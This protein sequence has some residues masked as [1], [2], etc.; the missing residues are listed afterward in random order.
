MLGAT[1]EVDHIKDLQ[2]GGTNHVDNLAALCPNCTEIKDI[3]T[4]ISY[5]ILYIY[6]IMSQYN[7]HEI[8]S[9]WWTCVTSVLLPLWWSFVYIQ[10]N[11]QG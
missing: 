7:Y 8:L 9:K 4:L 10:K 1:F 3:T 2:Y 6:N 11:S 5:I